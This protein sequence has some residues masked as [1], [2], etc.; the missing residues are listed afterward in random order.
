[1][2][3]EAPQVGRHWGLPCGEKHCFD[4]D[5]HWHLLSYGKYELGNQPLFVHDC[6][7]A[8]DQQH[9]DTDTASKETDL[10]FQIVI[11]LLLL[12]PKSAPIFYVQQ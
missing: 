10:E 6:G 8:N 5:S 12:L 7:R 9:E 11:V 2:S 4:D 1:M 3:D